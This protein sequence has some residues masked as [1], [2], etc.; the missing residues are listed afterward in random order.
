[1]SAIP[2]KKAESPPSVRTETAVPI[3]SGD[4]FLSAE[5]LVVSR[6][7]ASETR[8]RAVL[9]DMAEL[10]RENRWQD[11][12][13]LFAPVEEKVPFLVAAG[14]DT[15]VREK[16]AFALGQMGRYD[17][18]MAELKK[19]LEKSPDR[20]SLH[21]SLAYMAYNSLFAAANREILL[22]GKL[23]QERIRLAHT[24]FQ[25]A[26]R[27][28]PD[29]VTN[30]Y[31]EGMLFRRIEGKPEKALPLFDR[32]VKNWDGLSPEDR[33]RRHQERKN[34]I[35]S[36][37][38]AASLRLEKNDCRGA[39]AALKRCMAEDERTD[40]VER[41]F[42]Y[43]ALG[44]V[45]YSLGRF[46]EARDALL[47]AET[48]REGKPIDFVY[49]LLARVFLALDDP[50]RAMASVDKTPE[51]HR[52]PYYRWTEADT[53]CAM[54]RFERARTVLSAAAE[55]DNRSRHKSL[56]RLAKIDY[57]LGDYRAGLNHA[58]EADRFFRQRWGNAYG[59]G[60]FWQALNAFRAGDLDAACALAAELH[61]HFP[62][63]PK[64]GRLQAAL[65][66]ED[67]P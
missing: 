33:D 49:E 15:A 44:K 65:G 25:A 64:L 54:K 10:A 3:P 43:F 30:F 42:K 11:L 57:L 27:L 62:G 53:L 7:Q 18:A 5:D 40:Y 23:R 32:A 63:Y 46:G 24:H 17:A 36:L 9:S 28:R 58:A 35:K 51:R 37:Y 16:I 66:Q 6:R 29:G 52:R 60:L 31:R 59:H 4:E 22:A 26:Q 38:Q 56:I 12:V 2:M 20:F 61:D 39:A 8:M 1:M 55:R 50:Q 34:V 21:N 41:R 13:A 67:G 19:C 45:E 14:L 48:C 47:F